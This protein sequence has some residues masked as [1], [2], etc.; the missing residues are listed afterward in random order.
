[1]TRAR[2]LLFAALVVGSGGARADVKTVTLLAVTGPGGAPLASQLTAALGEMYEVVDG[3]TY[4]AAA[5]AMNRRSP[6]PADVSAVAR[7][8]H[9]DAL[10][11][12]AVVPRGR[13]RLVVRDGANG[14][15]VIRLMYP[16][17]KGTLPPRTRQEMMKDLVQALTSCSGTGGGARRAIVA[18]RPVAQDTDDDDD[19]PPLPG[20]AQA[21]DDE[22]PPPPGRAA[23]AAD[24][25]TPPGRA[26]AAVAR[27]APA[28]MQA[29]AG[30]VL[31]AGAGLLTRSFTVDAPGAVPYQG[32]VVPTLR[33]DAALFPFGFTERMRSDH[34][35][36]STFG[37]EL[38]WVEALPF[39]SYSATGQTAAGH[40][41]QIRAALVSRIPFGGAA[42]PALT[43]A[44]GFAAIDYT[45]DDAVLIGVPDVGYR[46]ATFGLRLEVPLGTPRVVLGGGGAV[47]G[48]VG[49]GGV[50]APDQYGSSSGWGGEA[51]V[52]LTV[53]PV[54]WLWLRASARYSSISLTFAGDGARA[55][56]GAR[57]GLFDGA[58]EIG[59]SG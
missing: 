9:I 5:E 49:T 28:S 34:P 10:V 50:G 25:E 44:T 55:A 32:G 19:A 15:V 20:R 56:D 59:Y 22:A 27:G 51:S 42:R 24:D 41:R 36:L 3:G 54:R 33:F 47:F 6:S 16:L 26:D 48:V 12:G 39:Q 17:K 35:A 8:Q 58:F 46:M 30:I 29:G 37:L 18:A 23:S 21:A 40:A 53:R 2:R 52:G 43:I 14:E 4:R 13:L 38:S 7:R 57:D 11:A 1:M 31:G 45:S